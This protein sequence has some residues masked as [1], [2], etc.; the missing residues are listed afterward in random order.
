MDYELKQIRVKKERLS[1]IALEK[2]ADP[3]ATEEDRR[4]YSRVF[5]PAMK[6]DGL[7]DDVV[8]EVL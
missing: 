4:V 6:A 1:L 5:T 2:A 8:K 3:N 7:N